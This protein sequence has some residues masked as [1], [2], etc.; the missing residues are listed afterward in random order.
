M[1]NKLITALFGLG[2]AMMVKPACADQI[3]TTTSFSGPFGQAAGLQYFDPALGTLDSV[4]V[5]ISGLLKATVQGLGPCTQFGCSVAPY[6]V[7]ITQNFSSQPGNQFFSFGSPA[8]LQLQGVG[9]VEDFT[10][11]ATAF[12]YSF[13]FTDLSDL[14]GI[15]S[16]SASGV[17]APPIF[18]TGTRGGFLT[19]TNPIGV[20]DVNTNVL[21]LGGASQVLG[22][23]SDG[24]ITITYNYTPA[25][26]VSGVPESAAWAPLG[27]F[28][29]ALLAGVR[30]KPFPVTSTVL[31]T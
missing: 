8:Q 17:V 1:T 10:P 15:V 20:I 25:Q 3:V 11:L 4:D 16:A 29:V 21:F 14:A 22:L 19:P 6:A 31:S 18:V 28:L 24:N 7:Q 30:R 13:T 9:S 27:G 23:E 5:Q 2:L 12:S 26:P